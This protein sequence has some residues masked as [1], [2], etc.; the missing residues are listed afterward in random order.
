MPLQPKAIAYSNAPSRSHARFF[1]EPRIRIFGAVNKKLFIF[2]CSSLSFTNN[3]YD[4]WLNSVDEAQAAW[5]GLEVSL[6]NNASNQWN[7]ARLSRTYKRRVLFATIHLSLVTGSRYFYHPQTKP[8]VHRSHQRSPT[9]PIG[10]CQFEPNWA[11][12]TL[13]KWFSLTSSSHL[14]LLTK[15][16]FQ[17]VDCYASSLIIIVHL[18]CSWLISY[19]WIALGLYSNVS[20]IIYSRNSTSLRPHNPL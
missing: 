15:S 20:N 4:C 2:L 10:W 19:W 9:L 5:L 14:T 11:F 13:W 16:K 12:G 18:L 6:H 8:R 3:I 7:Y 1:N 17:F